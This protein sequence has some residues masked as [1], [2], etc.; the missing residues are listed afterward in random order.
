[1]TT[2][3]QTPLHDRHIALGAKMVDF[4]GWQMPIMYPSGIVDE[5]LATRSGVGVF[6]V[7]HMGRFLVRGLGALPLLQ[8]ILSNNAAALDVG[9][10]QYTFVPTETGGAFDDA[11]LYRFFEDEYLLVVNA[12]NRESDWAHLQAHI[13]G[14]VDLRLEDCTEELAMLSVQG[15]LSRELVLALLESGTL[16]EPRRNELSVV[17]MAGTRVLVGRTGYTGEPLCFELFIPRGKGPLVWDMLV[18]AGRPR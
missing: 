7:S 13:G 3:R 16:P 1:M 15:P 12:A 6:D 9:Q 18:R 17:T 2:L 14:A 8:R 5:H 11:Y 10:A 4:A